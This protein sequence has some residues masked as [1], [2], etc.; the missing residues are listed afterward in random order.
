MK[1]FFQ[2]ISDK[3]ADFISDCRR[4][5]LV[6]KN[7]LLQEKENG[8][9]GAGTACRRK[10]FDRLRVGRK[11]F[12][13]PEFPDFVGRQRVIGHVR[14]VGARRRIF[15]P[16]RVRVG[17]PGAGGAQQRNERGERGNG[18]AF[19]LHC[20]QFCRSRPRKAKGKT[21]RVLGAKK[22]RR[23]A[24]VSGSAPRFAG[25]R[26]FPRDFLRGGNGEKRVISPGSDK[27]PR[28]CRSRRRRRG[29]RASA[30][31]SSASGT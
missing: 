31:P 16:I 8:K 9:S 13:E 15:Q 28:S 11:L 23:A 6:A 4:Y 24:R 29:R 10:S 26:K 12:D 25:S 22:K 19:F 5:L 3:W 1:E 30:R 14:G 2:N 21:R 18:Q 17:I 27:F 7:A 20:P